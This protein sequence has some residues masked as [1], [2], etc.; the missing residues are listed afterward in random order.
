MLKSNKRGEDFQIISPDM[1]KGLTAKLDT[2]LRLTGGITLDCDR[3]RNVWHRGRARREPGQA[4]PCS[5]P[6][7]M[8]A[9]CGRAATMAPRGR[10]WPRAFTGLPNNGEVYVTRI[11]A[12]KFDANV[13]YVAFDN[14]RNGDFKPYLFVSKDGGKSFTS[15]VN[16]LPADGNAD[17]LH[18]V[19]EDPSNADVLVRGQLAQRVRLDR[20]W[21]HVVEAGVGAAERAGVR[22]ADSS[23]RS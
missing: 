3:R 4:W 23:A 5:M 13:V 19:R 10:T 9:T 2:A 12:S 11:E 16:N 14:H 7:P 15:L 20:S 8:M 21:R 22:S 18:V 6:A 17:F 1:S